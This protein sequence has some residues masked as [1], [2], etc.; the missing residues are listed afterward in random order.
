MKVYDRHL[1]TYINTSEKGDDQLKFLYETKL[2]RTILKVAIAPTFSK[3]VAKYKK[4]TI[5]SFEIKS[6]IKNARIKL[7]E[8]ENQDFK[9]INDVFTRKKKPEFLNIDTN[10]NN[11][12]APADSKLTVYKISEVETVRIK[13][14]DYTI[15]E[16]LNDDLKDKFKNGYCLVFRL[17]ISDYHRY[18]YVDNATILK[19][20]SIPGVLNTVRPIISKCA[21]YRMNKRKWE[22]MKTENFGEVVQMEVG[23]MFVG[24]INNSGKDVVKKG[25]EKGHFS[26]G[27]STVVV[28]VNDIKIDDDI[29]KW[30]GEGVESVVRYGERIGVKC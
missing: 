24:E 30:S 18:C 9:S 27:G 1:H 7:E 19:R 21:V 4:S 2:G 14:V 17:S 22:L 23:A 15:N 20:K 10:K 12:I 29:M 5:S 16:L 3:I 25:E 26:I 28:L 8:Y 6:F 11:F 13:G